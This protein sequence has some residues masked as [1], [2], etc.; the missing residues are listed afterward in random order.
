M[1]LKGF[2]IAMLML[3]ACLLCLISCNFEKQEKL[4]DEELIVRRVETF[5]EAYNGGDMDTIFECLDTKTGKKFKA[6]FNI[7]GGIAGGLLGV[8]IDLTELFS[9]GVG[10]VD[11]DYMKL[12]IGEVNITDSSNAVVEAKMDLMHELPMTIYFIMVREKDDW[13]IHDLTDKKMGGNSANAIPVWK[14]EN[15][16]ENGLTEISYTKNAMPYRG[17]VNAEGRIIYSAINNGEESY[18]FIGNNSILIANNNPY[19]SKLSPVRLINENGETV[20]TWD[21]CT[22]DEILGYGDGF[23]MAYREKSTIEGTRY[24][25]EIINQEGN[26]VRTALSFDSPV[27]SE[28]SKYLGNGVFAACVNDVYGQRKDYCFV[29]AITGKQFKVN[30]WE[31]GMPT[32]FKDGK[33]FVK[34]FCEIYDAIDATKPSSSLRTFVLSSDGVATDIEVSSTNV[35]WYENGYLAYSKNNKTHI[36]DIRDLNK[37]PIIYE[38]YDSS[39]VERV[40][41][42]DDNGIL[43]LRGKDGR[44]YITAI[45]KN[46]KQ[47]VEPLATGADVWDENYIKYAEGVLVYKNERDKMCI[48]NDD[49]AETITEYSSIGYFSGGVAVAQYQQNGEIIYCFINKN[50]EKINSILTLK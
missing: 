8:D 23:F 29:N 49:G 14:S 6:M 16:C 38:N 1:K 45:D 39:M 19:T 50:G 43:A 7:I 17:V 15:N 21:V 33:M 35:I 48:L 20:K 42:N 37:Q 9:L 12:E 47:L 25:C 5:L 10:V 46:G 32:S 11:G 28:Y 26:P 2:L 24:I 27:L 44:I 13:Y 34:P 22:Y 36:V 40:M 18:I 3:S 4:T 30:G 41:M 31:G